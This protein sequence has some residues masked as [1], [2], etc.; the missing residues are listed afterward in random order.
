MCN[1]RFVPLRHASSSRKRMRQA[2]LKQCAAF[3]MFQVFKQCSFIALIHSASVSF[4]L[5]ALFVPCFFCC[6]CCCCHLSILTMNLATDSDRHQPEQNS[7]RRRYRPGQ[8]LKCFIITPSAHYINPVFTKLSRESPNDAFPTSLR[9]HLVS[10]TTPSIG[11][12]TVDVSPLS[13][14]PVPDTSPSSLGSPP[15]ESN[16]LIPTP[17]RCPTDTTAATTPSSIAASTPN[18]SPTYSDYGYG[19]S[20]MSFSNQSRYDSSLGL[21]TRKF[22]SLL[23]AS[24]SNCLDLNVAA[25]ELGVQKRRICKC[26]SFEVRLYNFVSYCE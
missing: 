7:F 25:S 6:Y 24:P 5:L 19:S 3:S 9:N 23:V 15:M 17:P 10:V 26:L 18:A 14:I 2:Q 16:D 1:V 21:L 8:S 11:G 4:S 22:V 13:G 12:T 20:P